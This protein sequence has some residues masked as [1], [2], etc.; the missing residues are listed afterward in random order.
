MRGGTAMTALPVIAIGTG[1]LL[2]VDGVAGLDVKLVITDPAE[3]ASRG[4]PL[5]VDIVFSA[6]AEESKKLEA[7]D[8]PEWFSKVGERR[9]RPRPVHLIYFVGRPMTKSVVLKTT[10]DDR[11]AAGGMED[12]ERRLPDELDA[13]FVL[14]YFRKGTNATRVL[15]IPADRLRGSAGVEVVLGEERILEPKFAKRATP[16]K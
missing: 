2:A 8:L 14:A 1:K 12:K 6:D 3:H 15:R 7:V 9:W 16:I 4:Y 13:V 10:G 11:V 5:Q